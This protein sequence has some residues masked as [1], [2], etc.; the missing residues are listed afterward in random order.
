MNTRADNHE[1]LFSFLK[2]STILIIS[3]IFLKAIN[4]F[5]LPLYTNNLTPSMLGVSD[6]ITT[7]TG[8]ILP[9]LT[10]GLDS[11]Y[12]AFYFEKNNPDRGKNVYSTLSFVFF[13]L[14]IVPLLFLFTCPSI[15]ALLFH[16]KKYS[17]EVMLS[18]LTV[19]INLWFL[20]YSLEIRLKNRILAFGMVNMIASVSMLMLNILFVSVLKIGE[21]SLILSAMIIGIEQLILFSS[22][23]K[24]KPKRRDFKL[25]LL[26]DMLRFSV[27][28]VP[29]VIMM[30]VLSLSDRYVIL[31]FCGEAAVGI[32]GIGLRFTHLLNVIV[33][34]ISTAYTTYAFSSHEDQSAKEQYYYIFNITSIVLLLISFTT[35][36]YGKEIISLMTEKAY[37]SSYRIL[38]DMMFAQSFYAMSTIIS[39]GIFFEKKSVY[40]L[41]AVSFASI[42]NLLLNL[43]LIPKYGIDAAAA[44]TLIGYLIHLTISYYYSERLYP[45][46]Y[47]IKRIGAISFLMYIISLLFLEKA[48]L[49]KTFVW[50]FVLGLVF[51]LYRN[52]LYKLISFIRQL[53]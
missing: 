44:T 9:L 42:T 10:L 14:G 22:I 37:L 46:N 17:L 21:L 11:A 39:Y 4:F 45:C 33:N 49:I 8:F 3:N 5:L 16:T 31:Y 2:G 26:K 6:S 25:D 30:W 18:F 28:M 1:K 13:M 38:R 23:V 12:S 24:S 43:A 19:A 41:I 20:P 7:M 35:G 50:I 40:S 52:L 29:S 47:G 32:Y 34:G 15:S 27:P 51:Y 53:T 48:F 36:L